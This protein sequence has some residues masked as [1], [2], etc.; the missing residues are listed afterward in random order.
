MCPD[1]TFVYYYDTEVCCVWVVGYGDV[2]E[3]R[4]QERIGERNIERRPV[5]QPQPSSSRDNS[6]IAVNGTRD[7]PGS[8]H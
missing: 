5:A 7:V 2:Y 4:D 8:L 1:I 6:L 3:G